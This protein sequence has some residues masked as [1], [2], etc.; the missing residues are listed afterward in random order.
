ME[1]GTSWVSQEENKISS[2]TELMEYKFKKY[3]EGKL[4]LEPEEL[5]ELI[6]YKSKIYSDPDFKF[7]KQDF[8]FLEKT[9]EINFWEIALDKIH[10]KA[11]LD[12]LVKNVKDLKK[13]KGDFKTGF[14]ILKKFLVNL[15]NEKE[16][17]DSQ[18]SSQDTSEGKSEEKS[19]EKKF[20][21]FSEF[22]KSEKTKSH[23][24]KEDDFTFQERSSSKSFIEVSKRRNTVIKTKEDLLNFSSLPKIEDK[25]KLTKRKKNKEPSKI[26]ESVFFS[27]FDKTQFL[28]ESPKKEKFDP[29]S[30]LGVLQSSVI[31]SQQTLNSILKN[32]EEINFDE[33][34]KKLGS[35]MEDSVRKSVI[36][37][38]NPETDNM[39][40]LIYQDFEAF[41]N[42]KYDKKLEVI[43]TSLQKKKL[44]ENAKIEE[45]L[46]KNQIKNDIE[47]A[48]KSSEYKKVGFFRTTSSQFSNQ[49]N[50]LKKKII[51][52]NKAKN[53]KE[54]K[55]LEFALNFEKS[56][57]ERNIIKQPNYATT[58][59]LFS[60]GYSR[61]PRP[62]NSTVRQSFF[63]KSGKNFIFNIV[64]R[65]SNNRLMMFQI[66][67]K[68][69]MEIWENRKRIV[70]EESFFLESTD[71]QENVYTKFEMKRLLFRK[72]YENFYFLYFFFQKFI[73]I[74]SFS[75]QRTQKNE[76]FL[77]VYDSRT[78]KILKRVNL[79]GSQM[80]KKLKFLEIKKVGGR[81]VFLDKR[82][83]SEFKIM[84]LNFSEC[85]FFAQDYNR[86]LEREFILAKNYQFRRYFL[87]NLLKEKPLLLS[88]G[89]R[90]LFS[91]AVL[92]LFERFVKLV[93]SSSTEFFLGIEK[94]VKN[95]YLVKLEE[96]DTAVNVFEDYFDFEPEEVKFYPE[97]DSVC[98]VI[99]NKD[100]KSIGKYEAYYS[101]FIF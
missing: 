30:T 76:E 92:L 32:F 21:L 9:T 18:K 88:T 91:D 45:K 74:F 66:K 47:I 99:Y 80:E 52:L 72:I 73:F 19:E 3:T 51:K 43:L 62:T 93:G 23:K 82:R 96:G 26:Y 40:K 7:S 81:V 2:N 90:F 83:K 12:K 31:S 28:E 34:S 60:T 24:K 5:K 89:Y 84:V 78:R 6:E 68:F 54:Y 86:S 25:K 63:G 49:K 14:Q 87:S 35:G 17:I 20:G 41:K 79:T 58:V 50:F 29:C 10:I 36:L 13:E 85:Q 46:M 38:L 27:N 69:V 67:K 98:F 65:A 70:K 97:N 37:N 59:N 42:G 33:K 39:H 4:E 57:E 1:K 61:F 8:D 71:D 95:L 100:L 48:L 56:E 44:P 22:Q 94:N 55:F 64:Y 77:E 11:I 75:C 101:D 16:F 15:K 53:Y